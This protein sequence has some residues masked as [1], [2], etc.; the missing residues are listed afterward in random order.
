MLLFLLGVVLT[1]KK[2][3]PT[4]VL[5]YTVIKR[6]ENLTFPAVLSEKWMI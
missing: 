2:E 6:Q 5:L 1:L 4:E 3:I